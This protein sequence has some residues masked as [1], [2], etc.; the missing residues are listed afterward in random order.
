MLPSVWTL[1]W[2]SA[3]SGTVGSYVATFRET[4]G[5]GVSSE[6]KVRAQEALLPAHCLDSSL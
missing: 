4:V 2:E 3:M 6:G 5:G 1:C